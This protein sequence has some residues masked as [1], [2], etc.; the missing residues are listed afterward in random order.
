ML[1]AVA[2][3]AVMD[4]ILKRLAG[5]YPAVQVGALRG[6]ASLPFILAPLLVTAR[7]SELRPH[8]LRLHVLRGV[9]ALI[10]LV[11]FVQAV[12]VLSLADA[13]A[14]FFVAPLLVT[15]MSVPLLGEHVDWQRWVAIGVGLAGV[16]VMLQPTGAGLSLWGAA[17]ALASAVAYA[18][19]AIT[20][21][22]LTRTDSNTSMVFWFLLLLTVFAGVLALP[23][24]VP[25]ASG[26]WMWLLALGGFG[27]LGQY[28]ITRAFRL[29][30]ASVIAPFEYTAMLWAVAIDW[31]VW[32]VLPGGRVFAG[33]SLVVACG[34]YLIWR[35][36]SL[37]VELAA[38]T[39]VPETP[40]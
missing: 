29:A 2:A 1:G 7:W 12:A 15:A 27:A 3:F 40:R 25:V 32:E 39:E 5:H 37:H 4:A 31:A 24:W 28:G 36:R 38:R 17:G 26:D 19:S 20:V 21:R 16:L 14:I 30:P 13:Y 22:I 8:N 18:A 6:A 23:G 34:L 33:G 11:G 9:L 10:M 35:E